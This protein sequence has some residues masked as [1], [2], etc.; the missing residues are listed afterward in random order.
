M[1]LKKKLYVVQYFKVCE[2]KKNEKDVKNLDDR[3][4]FS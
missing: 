1:W 4:D 3:K 2:R